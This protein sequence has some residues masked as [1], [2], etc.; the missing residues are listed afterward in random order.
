MPLLLSLISEIDLPVLIC[1]NPSGIPPL[2]IFGDQSK[3]EGAAV[4]RRA[5][6]GGVLARRLSMNGPT[7]SLYPEKRFRSA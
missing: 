4:V 2:N 5:A 7:I 1:P 3:P 6:K